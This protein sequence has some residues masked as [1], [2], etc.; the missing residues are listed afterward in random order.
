MENNNISNGKKAWFAIL[1]VLVIGIHFL[2]SQLLLFGVYYLFLRILKTP[3]E[4]F[5]KFSYLAE[6]LVNVI[7][8]IIFFVIYRLNFK[9]D[10][11]SKSA[12][13]LKD[14]II[15][16]VAGVGVSGFSF[17]WT[18][19]ADKIPI[20]HKSLEA[21]DKANKDIGGGSGVGIILL[22]VIA[23]PLVEELIFRGIVFNSIKRIRSGWLPIII[24]SAVFG[25]YHMNMVQAVYATF[26]GIVAAI[27]YER[28]KSLV[29]PI[30]LHMANNLI[31]AIQSF[32]SESGVFVMNMIAL[33]MLIPM[34]YIVYNLL[35]NK[36]DTAITQEIETKAF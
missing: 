31:G 20:F 11:S 15:S 3:K 9:N 33:A 32:T 21:M 2:L 1:P 5:M 27:I 24:S 36:A 19:L 26:I 4:Q 29:Y 8:M 35:K 10:K 14:S 22:A 34:C 17:L 16:V 7:L 12:F 25:A 13:N 28:K 6:M 23:A 30:L 18:I